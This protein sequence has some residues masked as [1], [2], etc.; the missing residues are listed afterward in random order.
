MRT[1]CRDNR[2]V[3]WSSS[4]GGGVGVDVCTKEDAGG[5]PG[6]WVAATGGRVDGAITTGDSMAMG[7]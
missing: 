2:P 5:D 1:D 7:V 3:V 4:A 6:V